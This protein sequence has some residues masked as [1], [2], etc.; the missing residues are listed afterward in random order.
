[1]IRPFTFLTMVLAASSGAYL[2]GVKHRAQVLDGQLAS[3]TQA[4]RLDEQRI[5]VLQAQWALEIDPNR[6]TTLASKFTQLQPMKPEQ[7]VT[8]T[9]LPG[10]LP[11]AGSAAPGANPVAPA[12]P[13][14]AQAAPDA[15]APDATS[16]VA[17][18]PMPPPVAPDAQIAAAPP[19]VP[20]PASLQAILPSKPAAS[21]TVRLASATRKPTSSHLARSEWAENLAPPRPLYTPG[22]VDNAPMGA[23]VM[24]VSASPMAA[25]GPSDVQGG[26][27][28]G[29]AS[30]MAPPQAAGQGTGN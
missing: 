30:D 17:M 1:M 11:P 5:R 7:L 15:T 26:S 19:G 20:S 24:S 23:R 9:A 10:L 8:L 4:S 14:V 16:Q 13:D 22:A 12:M 3:V 28:L 27:M 6:L 29:M 18:L 21:R 2:F 25:P